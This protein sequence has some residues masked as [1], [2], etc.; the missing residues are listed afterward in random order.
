MAGKLPVVRATEAVR[1]LKRDGWTEDHQ[2]GSHLFLKHANK[3]G[4]VCIPMHAGTLA[5]GT[6]RSIIHQA[7]LT[8]ELFRRLL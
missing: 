6:L 1:A 5:P 2:K 3:P 8:V 4:Y 7:G